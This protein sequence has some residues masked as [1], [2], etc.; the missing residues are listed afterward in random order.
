MFMF[1][2]VGDCALTSAGKISV[3]MVKRG[4]APV[5]LSLTRRN[6]AALKAFPGLSASWQSNASLY[7]F[8]FSLLI[9]RNK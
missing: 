3:S 9:T 5:V 8:I 7:R 1:L 2:S 4:T 6:P